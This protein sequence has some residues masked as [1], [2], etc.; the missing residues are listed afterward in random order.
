MQGTTLKTCYVTDGGV[1]VVLKPERGKPLITECLCTR[2]KDRTTL[3]SRWDKHTLR[4]AAPVGSFITTSPGPGQLI[5]SVLG[6]MQ[7]HGF[8]V[9]L[10][11]IFPVEGIF[12][13]ELTCVLTPFPRKSFG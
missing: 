2:V 8:A 12:P 3:S 11:I 13:L 9:P 1:W 7:R 4:L 10:G 6:L 5:G